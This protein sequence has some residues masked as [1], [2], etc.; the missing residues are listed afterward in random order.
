MSSLLV[1]LLAAPCLGAQIVAPLSTQLPGQAP[2]SAAM[3]AQFDSLIAGALARGGFTVLEPAPTDSAWGASLAGV[4]GYFDPHTGGVILERLRAIRV[5]TLAAFHESAGAT[6]LLLPRVILLHLRHDG[7][8]VEWDGVRERIGSAG[9]IQ[10]S[11]PAL[12]LVLIVSDSSGAPIHC[13]RGGIQLLEKGNFWHAPRRVDD[14]KVLTDQS[15]DSVAV[16][17]A[18]AGLIAHRPTC[19]ATQ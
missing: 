2:D 6:L 3:S 8:M 10:G 14:R 5:A 17:L 11:V 16:A 13:A 4:G 19:E 18:L 7:D 1:A 12:S 15:K 9:G